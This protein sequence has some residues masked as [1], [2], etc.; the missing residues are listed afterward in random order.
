MKIKN[1]PL[2]IRS[3]ITAVVTAVV[4][5]GVLFGVL[6]IDTDQEAAV[7]AVVDGLGLLVLTFWARQHVTP[8]DKNQEGTS[9]SDLVEK[10]ES[11]HGNVT[12]VY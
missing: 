1:E 11:K 6:P 5:A 9:V 3:V 10:Y 7:A 12:D 2:V 8:A 4:H